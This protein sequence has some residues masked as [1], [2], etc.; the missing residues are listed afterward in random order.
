[1]IP[2]CNKGSYLQS[3]QERKQ[4]EAVSRRDEELIIY[5][6]IECACSYAKHALD[7]LWP[8]GGKSTLDP[9]V[10]VH[11]PQSLQLTPDD[12]HRI[13]SRSGCRFCIERNHWL[14][15]NCLYSE[16]IVI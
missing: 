13:C 5:V 8:N 1:M 9:M 7:A 4:K 2:R 14:A 3:A 11:T 15:S 6:V 12:Q 16:T 10:G